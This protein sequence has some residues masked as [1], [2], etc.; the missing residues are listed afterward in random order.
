M[1]ATFAGKTAFIAGG[2]VGIG[3]AIAETLARQ[4]AHVSILAR[5][6]QPLRELELR[7]SQLGASVLSLAGDVARPGDLERAIAQ[8]VER[9]GRL[10]LA[11][12]HAG[13]AGDVALL[14]ESSLENWRRVLSVNLDGV[15]YGMKYE[16]AAMLQSGGDPTVFVT[17]PIS[18]AFIVATVLILVVMVMPA[19]RA[20]RM[21]IAD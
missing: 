6:P 1:T 12:N 8:V 16:I 18:A 13:I 19:V 14:H 11:V 21:E 20:R 3:A 9:C 17:R 5:R 4:G 2:S 10:D 7:L 15:F